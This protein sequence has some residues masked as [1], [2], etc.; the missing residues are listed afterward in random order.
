MTFNKSDYVKENNNVQ[1]SD[2]SELDTIKL[3]EE[4]LKVTRRREKVG[5]VVIRKE[6]ETRA[7]KVPVRRE[8]LIVERIGKNPELLTEVVI[9]EEN[10]NGFEYSQFDE[11][12]TLQTIRSDF[13]DV[14]TA[15]SLL[16]AVSKLSATDNVKIRLQIVTTS[17]ENQMQYQ[18]LCDRASQTVFTDTTN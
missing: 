13:L 11:T 2:L 12:D 1:N 9:S 10:V 8:K 6:I 15:K 17:S 18:D 16:E 7:I 5:E 3:L 4:K 14:Q